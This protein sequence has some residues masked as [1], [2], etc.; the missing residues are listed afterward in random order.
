MHDVEDGIGIGALRRLIGRRLHGADGSATV[1]AMP[2]RPILLAAALFGLGI[3]AMPGVAVADDRR[4]YVGSF[5]RVRVQGPFEV[6]VATGS[7][8][9]ASVS[10]D[11]QALDSV[12]VRV[13]GTTLIVRGA[14][15]GWQEQPR[16]RATAPVIVTLATPSLIGASVTG[17][18]RLS[19]D[20]M[21]GARVDLSVTGTGTIAAR[22]IDADQANATLVGNGAIQVAGRVT[23]ARLMT[24]GAG[25][26]DAA[27]LDAGDLVLRLDGPGTTQARARYTAQVTNTGLGS[28]SVVGGAKC[29]VK[30]DAG[31]PVACGPES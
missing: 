13:D 14:L 1:A 17:A 9:A 27:G 6:R 21:K 29:A 28:V 8:P 15:S 11:R 30:A 19:V 4:L 22:A 12:E 24:S 31:G 10:G 16:G 5:D 25:I 18:A 7:A 3:S 23:R 2:H 26:I 20:R